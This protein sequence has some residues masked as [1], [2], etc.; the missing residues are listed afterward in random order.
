MDELLMVSDI[1]TV[2]VHLD[3]STRNLIGHR[4]LA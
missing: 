3:E 1:N 2:H 4:D